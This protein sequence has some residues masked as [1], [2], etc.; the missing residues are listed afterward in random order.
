M[1]ELLTMVRKRPEISTAD[2]RHFMEHEYGS[3]YAAMPE[4]RRY[5]QYFL[6]DASDGSGAPSVDAIIHIAFSSIDDM[7][8][9][10]ATD[11]YRHAAERRKA[12]MV[13][14]PIGIHPTRIAQIKSFV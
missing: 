1:H 11:A 8:A 12:F 13:D 6:D 14:G 5:V 2:F 4:V 3:T 7:K 10:L 9:A